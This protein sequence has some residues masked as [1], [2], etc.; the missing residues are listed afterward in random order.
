MKLTVNLNDHVA[1]WEVEELAAE[2]NLCLEFKFDKTLRQAEITVV[3]PS[4]LPEFGAFVTALI[5]MN[6][7]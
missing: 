5:E 1:F 2:M 6:S 7:F 4:D 3:E